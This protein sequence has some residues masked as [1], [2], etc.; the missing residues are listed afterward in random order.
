MSFYVYSLKSMDF[1][2]EYASHVGESDANESAELEKR[3]LLSLLDR[4]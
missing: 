4:F 1:I 2:I 3:R